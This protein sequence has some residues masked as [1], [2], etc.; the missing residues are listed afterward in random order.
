MGAMASMNA[1]THSDEIDFIIEDCGPARAVR[2]AKFV[3]HA[4][5][6]IPNPFMLLLIKWKADKI[7]LHIE[8][9]NPIEAVR[10]SD[11]PLLIVHG[12]ADKAVPVEDAREIKRAAKN[13]KSRLEIF[14][15]RDHAYSICDRE[16]YEQIVEEF[17]REI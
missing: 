13:P 8:E 15:G 5:I 7:G 3:A 17:L 11:V 1:L 6:P 10:Q 4:M 2:G 12:D 16:R 9:N 14:P